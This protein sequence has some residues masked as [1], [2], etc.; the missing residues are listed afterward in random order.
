[1][2][3]I[4]A[5]FSKYFLRNNRTGGETLD[6]SSVLGTALYGGHQA[7][8]VAV[9]WGVPSLDGGCVPLPMQPWLGNCRVDSCLFEKLVL[10]KK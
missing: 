5:Q 4:L 9:E 7:G 10:R 3:Y 1:M 6:Q 2:L 8:D